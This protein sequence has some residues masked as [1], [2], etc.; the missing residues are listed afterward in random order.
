MTDQ[1]IL[2]GFYAVM[3]LTLTFAWLQG[4]RAERLGATALVVIFLLRLPFAAIYGDRFTTVDPLA[5]VQDVLVLA[6]FTWIGLSARRYWPLLAASLQLL[7]ISAHFAR[8]LQ[9]GVAEWAYAIMKTG[10]TLLVFILLAIGTINHRRRI[11]RARSTTGFRASNGP[12]AVP[13]SRRP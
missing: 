12:M 6:A 7:S 10:P 5:L 1:I 8:L 13:S 4:G 11:A 9:A 2:F 3:A